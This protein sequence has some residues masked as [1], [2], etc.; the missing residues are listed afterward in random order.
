MTLL[1]WNDKDLKKVTRLRLI[2]N[3][4]YP[5]WDVSYC[6][7]I[8]VNGNEVRVALP[9][10]AIKKGKIAET[11]I[12]YAKKDNV[13]AKGLGIFNDIDCLQ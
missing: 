9:F 10:A 8:D 11:I 7:G 5:V 13:Y 6:T 12:E 1:N 3:I 2:S 4:G